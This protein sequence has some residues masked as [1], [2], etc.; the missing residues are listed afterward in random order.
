MATITPERELEEDLVSKLRDLKYEYRPDISDREALEANFRKKFEAL[1]RVTLTDGEFQ[2]LLDEIVRPD[3]YELH[4]P[5][6]IGKRSPATT[7]RR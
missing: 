3:V 4:A 2:R 6:G 7:A 1:N 5:S